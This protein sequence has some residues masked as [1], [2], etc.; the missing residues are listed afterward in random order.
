[1][2]L[3]KDLIFADGNCLHLKKSYSRTGMACTRIKDG[4]HEWPAPNGLHP[5]SN[6]FPLGV[7]HSVQIILVAPPEQVPNPPRNVLVCSWVPQ[8]A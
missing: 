6:P 8:L 2:H 3:Q 1:M 4:L 5:P 7:G